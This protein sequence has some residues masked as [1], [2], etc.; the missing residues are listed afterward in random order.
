MPSQV[1]GCRLHDASQSSLSSDNDKSG[2]VDTREADVVTAA[3]AAAAAANINST[4]VIDNHSNSSS[5]NNESVI[6]QP[7]TTT[8]T[9][10]NNNASSRPR[11]NNK[12]QQLQ[13]NNNSG[14]ENND[15][16]NN[17]DSHFTPS[18]NNYSINS[19]IN[20]TANKNNSISNN[21]NNNNN[22]GRLPI[23]PP[24]PSKPNHVDTR[25]QNATQRLILRKQ[26]CIQQKQRRKKRKS[27][28]SIIRGITAST[29]VLG[30]AALCGGIDPMSVA[31]GS[32]TFLSTIVVGMMV[33]DQNP[34]KRART[35]Q[36]SKAE[37][38]NNNNTEGGD[39]ILEG[40]NNV[41]SAK[42]WNAKK[43]EEMNQT[44]LTREL[45]ASKLQLDMDM[46]TLATIRR[47]NA[48]MR[49]ELQRASDELLKCQHR[50]CGAQS[51]ADTSREDI[52]R[53]G[54]KL[55]RVIG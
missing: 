39:N 41:V 28:D 52:A 13:N 15:E 9:N 26:Q 19:Q 1:M 10:S 34:R 2:S 32:L 43:V 22:N 27:C 55:E 51:N 46:V 3:A 33:L 50:L 14:T 48:G 36:R 35:A 37:G 24:A 49:V 18:S 53:V 4:T 45:D 44:I 29:T 6:H 5:S 7:T 21:N 38:D 30:G 42:Q 23:C 16:N 11:I 12:H 40:G 8:S 17:N 54:C 20:N 25:Y 47:Q 31:A